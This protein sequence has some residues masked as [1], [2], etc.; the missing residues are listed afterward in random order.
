MSE[1]LK[2]HFLI[3]HTETLSLLFAPSFA[4]LHVQFNFAT[5][6]L[7]SQHALEGPRTPC[8][9]RNPTLVFAYSLY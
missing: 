4:P 3:F 6:H 2:N 8:I 5:H 7:H 1:T 9:R